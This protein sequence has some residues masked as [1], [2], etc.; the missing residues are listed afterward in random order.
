MPRVLR[1]I[2]RLNTG[3][4][5]RQVIFLHDSL[6]DKGWED[7]LVH[8]SLDKGEGDFSGA[9]SRRDRAL[10]MPE[11]QRPISLLRDM[12]VTVKLWRW[13]L[14]NQVDIIHSHTAKAGFV[15]RTAGIAFNLLAPLLG[16]R[17]VRLVHTFHGHVF[18][19]Y[20]SGRMTAVIKAVER[21][22]G[23]RSDRLI[24]LSPVLAKYISAEIGLPL[25]KVAV[26]P[27][28]LDLS[29]LL[30]VRR[31]AVYSGRFGV[32]ER[33]WIGWVGRLVEIKNPARFLAISA[34]LRKRLG[35]KVGFVLVGDGHMRAELEDEVRHLGLSGSVFFS[36]WQD[37]LAKIYS[38]L[39]MLINTS[40]NEGTPVAV[41]EALAAGVP[42]AATGVGGT[43]EILPE[44]PGTW[45]FTPDGWPLML[46]GWEAF[47]RAP[48]R[49]PEGVRRSVAEGFSQ[50]NLLSRLKEIYEKL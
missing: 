24:T 36:G 47:L 34:A 35:D 16:R 5:A 50:E 45:V 44:C 40:D 49:L 42:V 2:A 10:H 17:R 33:L 9:L 48:S 38:G 32:P 23:R 28:G 46:D 29:P 22:L 6:Q 25:A 14:K 11:L 41:L 31:E 19:G 12:T 39:D 26:V 21:F 13:L 4:P 27:L 7:F 8:G 18:S 1:V 15:A 20:F 3:G 43:G 37:D 30:A